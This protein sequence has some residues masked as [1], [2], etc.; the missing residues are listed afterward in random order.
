MLMTPRPPGRGLPPPR[1]GAD[2]K[3]FSQRQRAIET[4]LKQGYETHQINW[5]LSI[6]EAMA[7]GASLEDAVRAANVPESE[8]RNISE[9]Y[10]LNVAE[11]LK[12][13]LRTLRGGDQKDRGLTPA[14]H[15]G[16]TRG[17]RLEQLKAILKADCRAILSLSALEQDASNF[18]LA[19]MDIT[20]IAKQTRRPVTV[21]SSAIHRACAKL[22]DQEG[23]KQHRALAEAKPRGAA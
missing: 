1:P 12:R 5:F 10:Q 3:V 20:A 23:Q 22:L 4:L 17:K 15:P 16:G 14:S 9:Q 13:C 6:H 21:V 18:L 11:F 7:K 2:A 19:G 8:Q